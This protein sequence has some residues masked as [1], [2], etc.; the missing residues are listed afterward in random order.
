MNGVLAPQTCW[1]RHHQRPADGMQNL[2][3]SGQALLGIIGDILDLS[4]IEAGRFDLAM[5]DFD[6]REL[7]AEIT[8]L[9]CGGASKKVECIYFIA[10]EV[11][12]P[13]RRSAH[14]RRV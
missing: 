12:R 11:P 9:F 10:E 14:K 2:V 13:D 1:R 4:K 5:V 3:G 7:I 8:D 6:P